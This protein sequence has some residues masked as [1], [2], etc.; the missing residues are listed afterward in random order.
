MARLGGGE[1]TLKT[2]K[3][4]ISKVHRYKIQNYTTYMDGKETKSQE[5]NLKT[6]PKPLKLLE[7]GRRKP[8]GALREAFTDLDHQQPT[9][10][11]FITLPSN[12]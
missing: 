8:E 7:T 3:A 4:Y 10:R 1:V 2:S 5:I 6:C 9:A 12:F 11:P